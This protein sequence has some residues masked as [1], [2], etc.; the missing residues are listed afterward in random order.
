MYRTNSTLDYHSSITQNQPYSKIREE[1]HTRRLSTLHET[2][3]TETTRD[4]EDE[5]IMETDGDFEDIV[6][7]ILYLIVGVL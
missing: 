4:R 7:Y 3:T 2:H 5:G 6:C 1:Y